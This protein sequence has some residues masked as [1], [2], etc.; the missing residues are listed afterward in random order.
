MATQSEKQKMLLELDEASF[1]TDL[2]GPLLKKMGYEKVRER[3]GSQEYGKDI[4]FYQPSDLGGT[5]FAVVAK[6]GN[7]SGAASGRANLA[8][9]VNQIGMAFE[10]PIE[11]VEDKQE[12]HVDRVIVWTTGRISN[13]AQRQ[14]L[15]AQSEKFRNVSF[16]HGDATIDLLEKYYPAFF[17]IRD[18]Y[19]SD[20][21]ASAKESYSRLEELRALGHSSERHLLPLIFVPP[22]LMPYG[23][24]KDEK[25]RYSFDDLLT[26]SHN[27]IVV[28]EAGSGK[29]TLL[30]R[31]LLRIIEENERAG[32]RAPI[33]I[34]IQFKKLDIDDAQGIEKALNIEFSRFSPTGLVA[35]EGETDLADDSVVLLLDGLDELK[36]ED[37]INQ[38]LNLVRGF[39]RKYPQIRTILTSRL[40]DI[41]EK[42]EVLSNYLV[43]RIA[44][45][46]PVQMVE[47]VENWFGQDSPVGKRLARF[48]QAPNSLQ[49]LPKTPFT[50][51]LVAILY[52]SGTKEIPAN[53]TELFAKYVE[54]ALARWDTSKD[55]SL[56][57]EWKVKEFILRRVSW[58]LHQQRLLEMAC[59]DFESM[60]E[61]LGAER[62]LPVDATSFCREVL[63]RSEL[64]I[65][66]DSDE[67]EFKHRA[68]QEYFVG[69]EIN[70]R[71]NAAEIAVDKFHDPWWSRPIFFACGLR[72]D[73][74]DYLRIIMERIPLSG[75]S[76]LGVAMNLGLLAQA[77]YLVPKQ[78]KS[79]AIS[80]TLD[81]LTEAWDD[82]CQFYA[83]LEEKIE[84]EVPIP[85]HIFY[86]SFF[87][88]FAVYALGSITLASVLSELIEVHT[89]QST[90]GLSAREKA[91][92]EWYAYFLALASARCGR[93]EGF[94][95]VLE[96]GIIKDPGFLALLK[97]Q[98]DSIA[99]HTWLEDQERSIAKGWARKLGRKLKRCKR[100]L[101]GLQ[102]SGP[103]ALPP[104]DTPDNGEKGAPANC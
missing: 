41:F 50:I 63:D 61:R 9:I 89:S 17:T 12:Y 73:S 83:G 15:N 23:I 69:A 94:A 45:L 101:R 53:L 25:K 75:E 51:A 1:R 102:K 21:F 33:P 70:S 64:L 81:I 8:T 100:Y 6:V 36:T 47:F 71:A 99:E 10:M 7:I 86:L 104:P 78:T 31:M 87:S 11:D 72:P 103:L 29:S 27:V 49:G 24:K 68:F 90:I 46:T 79:K 20:Y 16:K 2:L 18:P 34:L 93:I 37:R 40:S 77:A 13:N 5:H 95:K 96:S 59:G 54:L 85:P 60:V 3:H 28:G 30:R 58:E 80:Y 74:E 44:G 56:Q 82:F 66:N 22:T 97:A 52:E 67:Y 76:D 92:R 65:R 48:V 35:P 14:I 38:A 4:T 39:N 62:G 88:G 26:T 84:D 98:A 32:Q 55:I 43:L 57:F 42:P 19:V 91:K